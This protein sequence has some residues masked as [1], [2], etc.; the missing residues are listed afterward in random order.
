MQRKEHITE[1][2]WD[3]FNLRIRPNVVHFVQSHYAKDFLK[4]NMGITDTLFLKDYINDEIAEFA[5]SHRDTYKRK[6]ICLYNPKKGYEKL[7]PVIRACRKDIQ[8]VPLAGYKPL[9]MAQLMCQA[10]L[11]VDFGRHPGKDRIPREAAVCGCCILTNQ[12]GSAAYP[13]DVGINEK[14]KIKTTEDVETVLETVY[15]LVDHYD[16]RSGEYS[17]YRV[18]VENEKQEFMQ[19][20]HSA[21]EILKE[22]VRKY[23]DMKIHADDL[24][25]HERILASFE[26]VAD[27][28][29]QLI[30]EAKS[31]C[32]QG[33]VGVI[34]KLLTTDYMLQIL[35]ESLYMELDS[36]ADLESFDLVRETR[37]DGSE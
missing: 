15:D 3:I 9:E 25:E 13:Q 16:E 8:W 18:T 12:E 6:N 23:E 20:V 27:Q 11:Y 36:L 32:Q 31:A 14:Y 7:E 1:E 35:R 26:S 21:V 10:K 24:E 2:M 33:R 34:D 29:K 28:M 30:L 5:A 37:A 22:R 4:R 17:D 19:E